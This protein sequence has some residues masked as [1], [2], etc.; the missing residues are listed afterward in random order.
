MPNMIGHSP[1]AATT[2]ALSRPVGA[3]KLSYSQQIRLPA[4]RVVAVLDDSDK[5]GR[6]RKAKRWY[7]WYAMPVDIRAAE[8]ATP[9]ML[10][11]AA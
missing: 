5:G 6:G 7:R 4:D 1:R 10:A 3:V 9:K 2:I 8:S 11:R